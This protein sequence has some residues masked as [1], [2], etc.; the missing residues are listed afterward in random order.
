LITS[1]SNTVAPAAVAADLHDDPYDG[2]P[3][4]LRATTASTEAA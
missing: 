3:V 2:E 1:R 4:L